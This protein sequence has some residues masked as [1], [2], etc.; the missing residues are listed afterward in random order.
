M[1]KNLLSVA[2]LTLALASCSKSEE[3]TPSY[4]TPTGAEI[5]VRATSENS[6]TRTVLA[7]EKFTDVE[8]VSGDAMNFYSVVT[9][10]GKITSKLPGDATLQQGTKL[11]TTGSGSSAD[12][13]AED[14]TVDLTKAKA[15]DDS[16]IDATDFFALTP[17]LDN[18]GKA[19]ANIKLNNSDGGARGTIYFRMPAD[20]IYVK[21]SFDPAVAFAFAKSTSVEGPFTFINQFGVLRLN[22]KGTEKVV[23]KSIAVT[24]NNGEDGS[25]RFLTG[26]INACSAEDIANGKN[27]AVSGAEGTIK[28]QTVTMS[29]G[30]GVTLAADA[31]AFN[32]VLIPV[33]DVTVA[34]TYNDGT[35][36]KTWTGVTKSAITRSGLT[37]M[38]E[39]DLTPSAGGDDKPAADGNNSTEGLTDNEGGS[40]EPAA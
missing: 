25:K 15:S 26:F 3:A 20:Q 22:L 35:E 36:D 23:V 29:C 37:N 18:G 17:Y 13:T 12:F 34:I 14:T 27:I 40:W 8:W 30:D 39:I 32:V 28:F 33:S 1:K 9:T 21:N 5:V 2:V 4:Q 16:P 19:A 11:T 10:D 24:A 38:P 31:T 6:S 7:G